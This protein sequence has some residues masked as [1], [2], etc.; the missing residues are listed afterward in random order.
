MRPGRGLQRHAGEASDLRQ[1]LLQFEHQRQVALHRIRLLQRMGLGEARKPRDLLV[2]LGV[3]FHRAGAERIEAG[4]HAEIAL[5]QREVVSHHIDLRQLRQ[6]A[7][8]AQ[9]GRGQGGQRDIRRRQIDA[10]PAGHAQLVEGRD[11]VADHLAASPSAAT[12][13]SMLARVL[14]SV[15][16]M[17]MW[18]FR[19]G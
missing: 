3:E 10:V 13:R 6:S 4:V 17:S 16:A 18:F 12:S 7:I 5:R 19:C 2:D 9:P 11:L 8:G 15:T 1:P 14:T